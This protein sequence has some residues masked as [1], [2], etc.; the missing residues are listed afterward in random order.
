M[1]PR[2]VLIPENQ[3]GDNCPTC[4]DAHSYDC[5][6][7]RTTARPGTKPKRNRATINLDD[8]Y[9]ASNSLIKRVSKKQINRQYV[10]QLSDLLSAWLIQTGEI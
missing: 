7:E 9:S 3:I 2:M 10:E 6:C 8:P 5:G 4:G 1:L